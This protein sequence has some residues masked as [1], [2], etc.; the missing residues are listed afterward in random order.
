MLSRPQ[1]LLA[2]SAALPGLYPD[3]RH[4]LRSLRDRGLAAEPAIWEDPHAP[5]D[6]ARLV[7]IRSTWDYAYRRERFVAW[8]ERVAAFC[9]LW[10]PAPVVRW[11]THK[12]YLLD[13]EKRG[14]AITPTLLLTAGS[15]ADLAVL[16][17]ERRWHTAVI[18]AAVGQSGRY[19]MRIS[20]D[21]IAAGQEHIDRLLPHEDMLV[22]RFLEPV[23]QRGEISLVYIE[24]RL[25]HAVR[26]KGAAGDFRVHDDY[27]GEVYLEKPSDAEIQV[28]DAALGAVP[29]PLLY[30]RVD[31]VEDE[32]GQPRV[33]EHELVEPE[34]FLRFAPQAVAALTRAVER[35]LG[36][37]R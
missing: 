11:N 18:K 23:I 28:A 34:L 2:T 4:L 31:L 12:R 7:L 30:A 33:M 19:A 6:A 22:Q 17:E 37:R 14:V 24:G 1:V 13:L 20:L 36:E 35:E 5:W 9:P 21:E 3:D 10:N 25:T 8:A 32:E 26:K 27:G 15:P 29:W 16:L